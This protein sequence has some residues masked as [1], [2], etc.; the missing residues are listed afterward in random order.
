MANTSH[1]IPTVS[2]ELF[3]P[4]FPLLE[5]SPHRRHCPALS[6]G[7]WLE[8]G[9]T[10]VLGDHCSGRSF[11]QQ[12]LGL[13]R[14]IPTCQH[15]FESLK[16]KRRLR[17]CRDASARLF[18]H[19]GSLLPDPLDGIHD[20]AG[21][22]VLAGDGHWIGHA[23]HDAPKRSNKGEETYYPVG[24]F[25]MLDLRRHTLRHLAL[26]DQVNRRKEHDMRAIKR[27]G[28][29]GIREGIPV[30]KKAIL[31][32][33]PAG[34]D[35]GL[36][37]D[38]KHGHG[39]YFISRTK[40][41]LSII[42]CGDLDW[43]R[44]DPVNRGVERD[45]QIGTATRGVMLRR[46][47]YTDPDSGTTYEF[48]TNEMTLR[49][50]VIALLYRMRWDIEKVFDELK[51]KLRQTKAWA[52]SATAKE[53]QAQFI[54]LAHN[55]MRLLED[56]L[57]KEGIGNATEIKRRAGRSDEPPVGAGA[58]PSPPRWADC[59]REWLQRFTQRGVKFIR[60]LRAQLLVPCP[61]DEACARLRLIY[62][63]C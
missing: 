11:L 38:L 52:K 5:A 19:A 55:L 42:R 7:R 16:S 20:L 24:H 18:Q 31:V 14:E 51:N 27:S 4:L 35:F 48:L 10:R 17:L 63:R 59:L 47:T 13:G 46:V 41:N 1:C 22:E 45:E 23:S 37:H 40:E 21:F 36:W 32:W 57:A 49:P 26:C 54:C 3:K 43:D 29:A 62:A 9:V 8:L 25:Y 2:K 6:D 33:D 39:I 12:A 58:A 56:K 61:W 34:I 44:A 28:A 60:W 15:F 30:G 53:M 50:G